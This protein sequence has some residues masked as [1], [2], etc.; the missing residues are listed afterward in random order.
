MKS[1][2]TLVYGAALLLILHGCTA[3]DLDELVPVQQE[4][5][6]D[7]VTFEDVRFV[8]DNMCQQC[9]SNPPQNGAPMPLVT[10]NNVKSAVET[11]GLLDRVSRQEGEQGLMPLGGPRLPQATIDLLFQWNE[12]GLL[13]N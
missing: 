5:P 12:D 10:Y 13:E 2:N 1:F 3:K 4:I 6:T 7:F 8:F 9:H 11:R